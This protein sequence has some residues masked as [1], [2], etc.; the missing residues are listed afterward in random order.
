MFGV[1]NSTCPSL[2]KLNCTGDAA[3]SFSVIWPV[4][5]S[6]PEEVPTISARTVRRLPYVALVAVNVF[7]NMTTVVVLASGE[8]ET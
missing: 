2:F 4:A 3:V 8:T 7:P 5:V 1:R 6:K